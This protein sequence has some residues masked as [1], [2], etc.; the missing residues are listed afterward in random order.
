MT[1]RPTDP[2]RRV[3]LLATALLAGLLAIPDSAEAQ[4]GEEAGAEPPHRHGEGGHQIDRAVAFVGV[5]V[6]SDR[7]RAGRERVADFFV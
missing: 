7:S 5:V 2:L 4:E 1:R 3:L 6:P